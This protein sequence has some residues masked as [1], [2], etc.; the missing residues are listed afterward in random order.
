MLDQLKSINV[1]EILQSYASKIIAIVLG[2][3]ISFWFDEWRNDRKD[4][5]TERK[6]LQNLRSNLVQD[7]MNIGGTAKMCEN[8]IYSTRKLIYFKQDADIVDSVGFYIDWAASYTGCPTNQTTYEEIKQTGQTNLIQDDTL[9]RA[10]LSHYTG[11][12]P[13]AK[14]W[15]DIDK[16][17]TMSYVIP[18]MSNY[19]PVVMDSLDLITNAQKVKYLKIPKLRHLLL[20]NMVYKKEAIKNLHIANDNTKRI[21]ARIDKVLASK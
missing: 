14:E 6:I 21:I 19:F 9:K 17:F 18:E 4:R 13:L 20:N 3:T 2:I 15:C 8:L 12:I 16:T 5:E 1:S 11:R 7:T 10:I